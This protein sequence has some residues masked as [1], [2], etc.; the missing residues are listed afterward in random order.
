MPIIRSKNKTGSFYQY[1]PSGTKY[2][3]ITGN[4]KSRLEAQEKTK[5]QRKAIYA[6][7]NKVYNFPD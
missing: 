2:Y 7:Q 1:G 6:S 3:Y 5:K 4:R